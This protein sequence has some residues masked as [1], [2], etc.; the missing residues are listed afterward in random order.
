[1]TEMGQ[2]PTK[3]TLRDM[4]LK[5]DV[6]GSGTVDFD[7]FLG[8]MTKKMQPVG[9]S[10]TEEEEELRQAFKVFDKDGNGFISVAE[11]RDVMRSLGLLKLMYFQSFV[12]YH[13]DR[14]E[15]KRQ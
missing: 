7:E 3:E 14:R 1:M 8:M 15:S 9:S 6:D 5:I 11:L 12:A 4:M 13:L 10:E 2:N